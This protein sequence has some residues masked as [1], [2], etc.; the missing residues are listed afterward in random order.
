MRDLL[1]GSLRSRVTA[2]AALLVMAAV[3]LAGL[4]IVARIDHRDRTDVDR[5]LTSRAEKVRQDADK[6]LSQGDHADGQGADDDYGGLL[7]GSQSLVRLFQGGTVVAQRGEQPAEA[8]PVPARDGFS[9]VEAGGRSWRSLVEPLGTGKGGRLQVLED[10]DP[11][12]QRLSDNA[13]LVTAV[14][15]VATALAGL[16]VWLITRALLQPLERLRAGALRI[17]PGDADQRLPPA[18]RPREVAD[19]SVALNAMLAQLQTS[20]LATRR[21]T[22]DAGHELRNPLTALG[23]NLETL[24]RNPGLPAD[25]RAEALTAMA[26]E[27]RRVAALLDGLQALARGDTGALPAHAAVDLPDLLA[28]AAGQARRRHPAVTYDLAVPAEGGP[29]TVDGWYPGLRLAVDN[30][31]DNAALHGRPGGRVTLTLAAVDAHG[32]RIGV[33]DDGPGIPAEQRD[34]MKGRFTRGERPASAGS[35]L[36]LAL[37]EQQ[38]AL[39]GG[40]LVLGA[41]PAG[42]LLATL[43]LPA[44]GP[45]G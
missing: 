11:I 6:L 20:M 12:Q 9:T 4:V 24:R 42:G 10:L 21:F 35:G 33:G 28:D 14:A 41:S 38:A 19:L 26:V 37:V 34:A 40:A 29:W 16:C 17:R 43:E 2:G 13:R 31:L 45:E 30:L 8:L 7:A 18:A 36:G 3:A 15:L 1:P 39:H 25:R 22:A 5:Q 32:V 27:Q 44:A 23:M